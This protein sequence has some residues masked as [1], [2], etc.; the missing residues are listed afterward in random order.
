[1]R[2][3]IFINGKR[4]KVFHATKQFNELKVDYIPMWTCLDDLAKII[5]EVDGVTGE[6]V[7][8][9]WARGDKV[10]KDSTQAILRF[11]VD[12]EKEFNPQPYIH[13]FMSMDRGYFYI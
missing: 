12:S 3:E 11:Y 13:F 4:V 7:D 9:R 5:Q 1:M 10:N 8:C 2:K 6:Y